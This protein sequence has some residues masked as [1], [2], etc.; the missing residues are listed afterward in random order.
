MKSAAM[1]NQFH[2]FEVV[3]ALQSGR[4]RSISVTSH[5][6]D[7]PPAVPT[8]GAGR[9]GT[10]PMQSPNQILRLLLL[11]ALCGL[12]TLARAQA[13][14]CLIEPSESADIGSP[15]VGVVSQVFVERGD[16][17]RRG[18]ALVQLSA[19]V[20]RAGFEAAQARS[21][22]EAE[23]RAAEAA[24]A[25]A[26]TKAQ[27]AEQLFAANF[28][29]AAARDQAAAELEL[30]QARTRQSREQLR[31]A[32]Q[33]AAVAGAQLGQRSIRSPI[34]GVV[35]ERHVGRGERVEDKPLLRV[36]TLDPLRVEVLMPA[37][38]FGRV[39]P[40]MQAMISPGVPGFGELQARVALVDRVIDAASNSFRV[41]LL[42]PNPEQQL[43]AGM[44]CKATFPSIDL[45]ASVA[46]RP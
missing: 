10:S 40:G 45:A 20:E 1:R 18:Q 4:L 28:V 24:E 37:A 35:V 39:R 13:L 11:A 6:G 5:R 26:Q 16:T 3:E 27:R 7:P 29:A 2:R 25:L 17:V 31:V 22:T 43:P 44:R 38:A 42:L 9:A 32:A 15:V 14:G 23:L 12:A 21:R 34:D 33:D 8:H 19:A 36:V 30:A 46:S 41:R